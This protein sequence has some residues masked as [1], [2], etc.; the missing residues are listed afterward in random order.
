MKIG[1]S[2][3]RVSC[4]TS[5]SGGWYGCTILIG[6]ELVRD[7]LLCGGCG[8]SR[9]GEAACASEIDVNV[10]RRSRPVPFLASSVGDLDERRCVKEAD[11]AVVLNGFLSATCIR[12]LF[13]SLF[14]PFSS[15]IFGGQLLSS[16]MLFLDGGGGTYNGNESYWAGKTKLLC[17]IDDVGSTRNII[18]MRALSTT[19]SQT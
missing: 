19:L 14:F 9:D 12:A 3:G 16:L 11:Q 7:V 10:S 6:L 4:S 2:S 15:G 5:S 13:L 18:T 17:R 8:E 1:C